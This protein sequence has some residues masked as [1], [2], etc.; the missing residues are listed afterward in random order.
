MDNFYNKIIHQIWIQG[1]E[2]IPIKYHEYIKEIKRLHPKWE[3]KFWDDRSIID[4]LRKQDNKYIE[5]YYKLDYLHQKV[6]FARYVILYLFGG[7]YIDMD[8]TTLKPIDDILDTN[9]EMIVCKLNLN[10]FEKMICGSKNLVNNGTIISKK[11]SKVL[12]EIIDEVIDDP[13]CN[14]MS[15]SFKMICINDTTGPK[16]FSNIIDKNK[17]LVKILEYEYFEPCLANKCNVTDKTYIFHKQERSWIS[18][19]QNKCFELYSQ[20]K[21]V[22]I[23]LLILLILLIIYYKVIYIN[24]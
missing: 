8:A 10:G 13:S 9:Y 5:A 23:I 4:L 3:Y 22:I 17:E 7:I 1:E 19:W 21:I 16:R 18:N 6:D 12:L 11:G 24:I 20:N 15:R 2:Y 14:S